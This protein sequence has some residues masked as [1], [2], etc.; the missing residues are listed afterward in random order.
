LDQGKNGAA[1]KY[2]PV[3]K[4][5]VELDDHLLLLLGDVAPLQIRPK[6]VDPSQPAA[7]PA[8]QQPYIK[9]PH[10]SEIRRALTSKSKVFLCCL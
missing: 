5:G 1:I 8:S 9:I 3:A 4:G 7:L 10:K 6:V 2:L